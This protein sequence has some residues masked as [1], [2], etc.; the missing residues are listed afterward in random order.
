MKKN[1]I[2]RFACGMLAATGLAMLTACSHFPANSP[3][4]H[5]AGGPAAEGTVVFTRPARTAIFFGTYS[6]AQFFEITYDRAT[7]NENGFL[8]VE[9]GVRNCGPSSWV[10][11][12]QTMPDS[13]TIKAQCN[14]YSGL[15]T[16][17][18]ICYS[19]SQQAILVRHGETYAYKAICPLK[20][21]QSYQLVLGD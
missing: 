6:L 17:S 9:V 14:F 20:E 16:N 2:S 15:D 5:R 13:I 18:P 12:Y 21:A 8:V 3:V 1:T 4:E 11:R 19:T 10:N 7:R